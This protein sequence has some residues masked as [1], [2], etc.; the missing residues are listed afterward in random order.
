MD[1]CSVKLIQINLVSTSFVP[2]TYFFPLCLQ[3]KFLEKHVVLRMKII[4]SRTIRNNLGL[5]IYKISSWNMHDSILIGVFLVSF[6]TAWYFW[7]NHKFFLQ[8]GWFHSWF[9]RNRDILVSKTNQ[10]SD[11]KFDTSSW[12]LSSKVYW[13]FSRNFREKTAKFRFKMAETGDEDFSGT[14]NLWVSRPYVKIL[15]IS[16]TFQRLWSHFC[17]LHFFLICLSVLSNS[18]LKNRALHGSPMGDPFKNRKP[19]GSHG[20]PLGKLHISLLKPNTQY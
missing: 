7:W 8:N 16:N 12:G 1:I 20:Y 13:K 5:K 17:V 11:V 19:M 9:N 14:R 10:I 18:S 3:K 2:K 4:D 6:L 15:V